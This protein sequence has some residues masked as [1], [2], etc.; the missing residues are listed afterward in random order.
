MGVKQTPPVQVKVSDA[1]STN[2]RKSSSQ[3]GNPQLVQLKAKSDKDKRKGSSDSTA[4]IMGSSNALPTKN[5]TTPPALNPLTTSI[6]RGNTAYERSV[7]GSRITMHSNLAP[8]KLW[9][10]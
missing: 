4:S 7:N 2:R 1:D 6:S 8:T 5:L 3:E 10:R 9:R